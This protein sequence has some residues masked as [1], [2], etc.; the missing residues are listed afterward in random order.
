[1]D[2]FQE[3]E[4]INKYLIE[5]NEHEARNL[6]IK[7]LDK[8]TEE[9]NKYPTLINHLIREVGLYPYI[10]LNSSLWEDR[11]VYDAFKVDVGDEKPVT[12]HR[13]QSSLLKKLISG[14]NIAVSAPTSFGKSFVIDAFISMNKPNK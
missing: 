10:D 3:C 12:L 9:D 7:L 6:L 5:N 8:L 14:E 13:E 4:N 1:M 2:I 11:F